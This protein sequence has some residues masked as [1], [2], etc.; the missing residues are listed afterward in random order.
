MKLYNTLKELCLCPS[1][2][3]REKNVREKLSSLITPLCDEVSTD[4]LGNL[5]A[6]KRC[7]KKNAKK[8]LPAIS[9]CN[10]I[11]QLTALANDYSFKEIFTKSLSK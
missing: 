11:S 9:L 2:S 3:G 1:V 7:G 6:T 8:V 4:A 5:I 10:N